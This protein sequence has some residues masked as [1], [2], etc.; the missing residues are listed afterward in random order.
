MDEPLTSHR[1]A[2]EAF[3]VV[4][5]SGKSYRIFADGRI[6]G[7]QPGAVIF[8]Y[9]PSLLASGESMSQASECPTRSDVPAR[10]GASHSLAL[11]SSSEAAKISAAKK[12]VIPDAGHAANMDQPEAFNEA[13][14]AF[15]SAL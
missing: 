13:V 11:N 12:I 7:F 4:E 2:H 3:K 1:K 14:K 8:N 10:G 9:I 15:L 5:P 6:E